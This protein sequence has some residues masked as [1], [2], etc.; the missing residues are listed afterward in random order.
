MSE[1]CKN[2]E[3]KGKTLLKTDPLKAKDEFINA[4]ECYNKNY[5]TC[6][7]LICLYIRPLE[8]FKFSI[9]DLNL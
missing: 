1:K 2:L 8:D 3:E 9:A 5:N 4:A 7:K 6:S